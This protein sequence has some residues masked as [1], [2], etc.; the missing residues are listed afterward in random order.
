VYQKAL[1]DYFDYQFPGNG[2]DY[3]YLTPAI[4]R[5]VQACGRVHR[6]ATD[7][8]CIVMLDERIIHPNIRQLLPNYYQKEMK[9]LKDSR[10]CGECI[11]QFWN[12]HRSL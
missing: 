5:L 11:T 10:E 2:R 8:G 12:K 1:I 3:A 4:F 7:K 9:V 6:S